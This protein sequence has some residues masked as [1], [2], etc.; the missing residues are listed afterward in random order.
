M[1]VYTCRQNL[2][3]KVSIF[4]GQ[5]MRAV[6]SHWKLRVFYVIFVEKQKLLNEIKMT[7]LFV[8]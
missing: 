3:Q 2:K 6:C 1:S 4:T 8:L 7:I 5:F